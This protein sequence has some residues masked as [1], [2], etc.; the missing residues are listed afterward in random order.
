MEAICKS[1]RHKS[2]DARC[3]VSTES[4]SIGAAAPSTPTLLRIALQPLHATGK[5]SVSA[6]SLPVRFLI[7]SLAAA[8]MTTLSSLI[9]SMADGLLVL[10]GLSF[11]ASLAGLSNQESAKRSDT[12]HNV[13]SRTGDSPTRVRCLH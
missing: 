1:Q 9:P 10:S 13:P 6:L 11:I 4:E 3:D 2:P 5:V 12:Q 7:V 8:A